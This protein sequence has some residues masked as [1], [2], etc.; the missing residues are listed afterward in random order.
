MVLNQFTSHKTG[1]LLDKEYIVSNKKIREY[2]GPPKKTIEERL[3]QI[4]SDPLESWQ[5]VCTELLH[6]I[7]RLESEVLRL[8]G[9]VWKY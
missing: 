1:F 5:I 9:Q 4:G 6:R 2:I 7:E 8:S 3:G